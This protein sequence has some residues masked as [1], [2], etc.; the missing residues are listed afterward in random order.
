MITYV[1][2]LCVTF[3]MLCLTLQSARAESFPSPPPYSL[4]G[5]EKYAHGGSCQIVGRALV[6]TKT[7]GPLVFSGQKVDILPLTDYNVWYVK[8]LAD[9]SD[10]N[11]HLNYPNELVQFNHSVESEAQ[12]GKVCKS[13][14]SRIA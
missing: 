10:S 2:R 4:A 3:L 6:D 11:R 14:A 5:L 8:L 12:P 9:L 1:R 13:G 7:F